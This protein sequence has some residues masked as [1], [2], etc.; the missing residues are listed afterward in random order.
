MYPTQLFSFVEINN[1][2]MSLTRE[3]ASESLKRCIS[4]TKSL[5]TI[6]DED[7]MKKLNMKSI[8]ALRKVLDNI[9]AELEFRIDSIFH[10]E[11]QR[12]N[13]SI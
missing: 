10:D 7:H 3:E 8:A 1:K 13:V 6:I 2:K 9:V 11:C 12:S 5:R 4:N